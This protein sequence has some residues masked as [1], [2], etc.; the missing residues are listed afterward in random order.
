MQTHWRKSFIFH[1][2]R[3]I[4]SY[5]SEI[6]FTSNKFYTCLVIAIWIMDVFFV[7]QLSNWFLMQFLDFTAICSF[8]FS[9][10]KSI[11]ISFFTVIFSD[12]EVMFHLCW[13]FRFLILKT[14]HLS[15]FLKST[16]QAH[17]YIR[18]CMSTP[19]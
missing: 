4:L 7:V 13:N 12:I 14:I 5:L 16:W 9:E 18:V 6:M 3:E 2:K 15:Y 8:M 17:T 1:L 19:T 10:T 11:L